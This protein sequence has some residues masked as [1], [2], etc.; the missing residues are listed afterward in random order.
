MKKEI[1]F[2]DFPKTNILHK[3]KRISS[4]FLQK[5]FYLILIS[6]LLLYLILKD[7]NINEIIKSIKSA[8]LTLL[9][10]AFSLHAIGLTVSAIRWKMLLKSL[11][12]KSKISY[13]VKSYLV[14]T[15]FNHFIP[16][17]IGG[18]SVRAYD[19]YRLGKDKTK[20]FVVV[21]IDRF[22]GLLALLFLVIGSTFFSVEISS[23]V[24]SLTLWILF[25]SLAAGMVLSLVLWPPMKLFEKLRNRPN[26]IIAKI[27]SILYKVGSAFSQFS[28][29]KKVLLKSLA[30][31]FLLQANVIFYYYL[32]SVSLGFDVHIINFSLIIP[33]TIFVLMIPISV[34]GIGLREN[35]LYFFFSFFGI[36]KTQVIAFAWIEFSMLLVLGII[37]GI[38]YVLRK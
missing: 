2:N 4:L 21:M 37:G 15:F 14:A 12:V 10:I 32:I 33:L 17:T 11:N 8:N 34:N 25:F 3:A 29:N 9:I 26:K 23:Q 13:L 20:G 16:S 19:S 5:K 6:F 18:D 36:A 31:S 27:G 24:P 35:V 1:V 7:A 22:L 30:L 38:V 28:N